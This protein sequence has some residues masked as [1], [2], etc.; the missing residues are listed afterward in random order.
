MDPNGEPQT[1]IETFV[2]ADSNSITEYICQHA[3]LSLASAV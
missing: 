3:Q 1:L 2:Q